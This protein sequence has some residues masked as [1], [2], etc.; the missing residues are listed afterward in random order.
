VAQLEV[1]APSADADT[2]LAEVWVL[3]A[4]RRE[5]E[6]K[7][8]TPIILDDD[9]GDS[10][11]KQDKLR[12]WSWHWYM[13]GKVVPVGNRFLCWVDYNRGFVLLCDMAEERS[14]LRYVPLPVVPPP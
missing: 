8:A 3:H 5:W 4:G 10:A 2:F 6:L 12:L 11:V 9:E 14:R 13:G 1:T 7:P